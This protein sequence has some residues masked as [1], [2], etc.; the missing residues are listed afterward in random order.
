MSAGQDIDAELAQLLDAGER[1]ALAEQARQRFQAR[2]LEALRAEVRRFGE[3]LAALAAVPDL[4]PAGVVA[5]ALREAAD[6]LE[7]DQG[8]AST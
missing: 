7:H 3:E 8:E 5:R 1:E 2:L 6:T 4:L